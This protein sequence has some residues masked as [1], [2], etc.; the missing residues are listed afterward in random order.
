MSTLH[1]VF[2]SIT[3]AM[4]LSVSALPAAAQAS[5][6]SKPLRLIVPFP[7]GGG[8]DIVARVIGAKLGETLG[9]PV[10]VET[11]PGAS[12]TLGPDLLPSRRPTDTRSCW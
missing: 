11:R 4:A 10:L 6:P 8:V 12:A 9:Q 3:G 5:F 1:K 7:P 2:A